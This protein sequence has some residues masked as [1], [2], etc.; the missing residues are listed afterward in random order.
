MCQNKARAL[1]LESSRHRLAELGRTRVGFK[2]E[3][4]ELSSKT[5]VPKYGAAAF[6]ATTAAAASVSS[7][8][9]GVP[10]PA[11]G[12]SWLP[13]LLSR[14]GFP[15]M[16]S[17]GHENSP[18]PSA[19]RHRSSPRLRWSFQ[20][21]DSGLL[22][23][24]RMMSDGGCVGKVGGDVWRWSWDQGCSMGGGGMWSCGVRCS[25]DGSEGKWCSMEVSGSLDEDDE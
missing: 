6:G 9:S 15:K 16:A 3:S 13:L 22:G 5:L 1:G 14:L 18:K 10:R 19:S 17:E 8:H 24:V 20:A 11:F 4:R 7:D 23:W 25:I 21:A 12:S 2:S